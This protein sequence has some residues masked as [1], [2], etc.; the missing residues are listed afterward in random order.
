MIYRQL[1]EIYEDPEE[2]EYQ[3]EDHISGE[4]VSFGMPD[5]RT[6]AEKEEYERLMEA[7]RVCGG[8]RTEAAAV[9]G[10]GRTSLWRKMKKYGILEVK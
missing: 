5:F 6:K 10:I 1:S 7:L 4:R 8:R 9:L 3:L 2:G